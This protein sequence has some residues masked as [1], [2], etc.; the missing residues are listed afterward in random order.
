MF[1]D[2]VEVLGDEDRNL[3]LIWRV[4]LKECNASHDRITFHDFK[5]ILKGQPKGA[6]PLQ[7]SVASSF[8]PHGQRRLSAG[9]ALLTSA[10]F[11]AAAFDDGS[12]RRDSYFRAFRDSVTS[13]PTPNPE[14][15]SQEHEAGSCNGEAEEASGSTNNFQSTLG[16]PLYSRPVGTAGEKQLESSR[17]SS[18]LTKSP[19][20][21]HHIE[22]RH[23]VMEASKRFDQKLSDMQTRASHSRASLIMKRGD[24]EIKYHS[25]A[26]RA[27]EMMSV[28][29]AV[30]MSDQS[31]F[32]ARKKSSS[33]VRG[34]M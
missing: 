23:A 4:S 5:T 24:T 26:R 28:D 17:R 9:A 15:H 11:E 27:S 30:E 16:L 6:A 18:L 13:A 3:E 33:D 10:V 29:A 32:R 7:L 1:D 22:M 25:K 19:L 8:P 12:F 20:Y 2:V 31:T 34:M 14:S 21:R